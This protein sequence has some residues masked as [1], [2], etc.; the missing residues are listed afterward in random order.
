M[1]ES[2]SLKQFDLHR[3]LQA[4]LDEMPPRD[5]I[6]VLIGMVW[7]YYLQT[8]PEQRETMMDFAEMFW[9]HARKRTLNVVKS[10]EYREIRK[11]VRFMGRELTDNELLDVM[12]ACK[13]RD[14]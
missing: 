6:V 1:T 3:R 12:R 4:I 2:E 5:A 14:E 7:G 10:V 9:K 11:A 8:P 13:F